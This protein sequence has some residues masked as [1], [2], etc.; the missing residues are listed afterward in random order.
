M[1][2]K[3]VS[4]ATKKDG[5]VYYRSSIT[6]KSK[7]ISLGSATSKDVANKLYTEADKILK[8]DKPLEY[9]I[10]RKNTLAFA[11]IVTLINYR[12]SGIYIK[13]P[14]Y[15]YRN[16]FLYYL[17][18]NTPLIFDT[19]D[20]FYYSEHK[21]QKKGGY[22]FVAD[23]GMQ[24][25]ILS[26]YGIK[27]Y[28]VEGKDY[29]HVNQNELDFTYNNIEV[30]NP[31]YG[32]THIMHKKKPVYIARLHLNGQYLIGRYETADHAAIAYNKAVDTVKNAGCT[33][34]FSTNY[35]D[36]MSSSEYKDVYSKIK[37][38]D[39]IMEYRPDNS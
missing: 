37:L 1:D 32:V 23:Y 22:M 2:L 15:L 4:K 17:D 28:S 21:I 24:I 14:I 26:R 19:D 39:K 16:Y 11:K 25:N 6:Y 20:L 8:G 27:N 29:F 34:E 33:K 3:G 36:G 7:H 9:Y 10:G 5:S 35:I 18:E 30:V 38:S 13:N 31:Y 12:D